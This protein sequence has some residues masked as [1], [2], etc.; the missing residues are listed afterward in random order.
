[1]AVGDKDYD[2][3]FENCYVSYSFGLE[4][5][6]EEYFRKCILLYMYCV[7]RRFCENV[8]HHPTPLVTVLDT[9]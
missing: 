4:E 6:L 7:L 3:I 5:D 1:M 9:S 2:Q 8:F